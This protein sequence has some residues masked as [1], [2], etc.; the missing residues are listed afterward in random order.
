MLSRC[1]SA[2][3]L[4]LGLLL[5]SS[6]AFGQHVSPIE[7]SLDDLASV[8]ISSVSKYVQPTRE[9][10]AAV[11]VISRAEISRY[12]WR[13]L[14]EALNSLP[15]LYNTN[16]RA[17]DYLGGRGFAV[18]G[19]YN[20][21]YL[22]LIDGSRVNDYVYGQASIGR[23]FSLD[24]AL[25]ERI[26]FVP[27][28]GSAIY[29]GNAIFGVINVITRRGND[30]SPLAVSSLAS[31][32]G[33]REGRIAG[34]QRYESG[35]VVTLSYSAANRAGSDTRYDDPGNQ[36]LIAG[37][38]PSPDGIARDL[39]HERVR[40]LLGRYEYGGLTISG[41]YAERNVQPSSALYGTLF[42]DPALQLKDGIAGLTGR[43]QRRISDDSR[44]ELR[45]DYS[46]VTYKGTYPYE[47]G[48]GVRY[49]NE[50][51]TVGTSWQGD[52]RY[53]YS[54]L[55]A[56][57]WLFGV[58]GQTLNARQ[59]NDNLNGLANPAINIVS[60]A[61][62]L[63]FYVQDEW[64]FAPDWRLSLGV[65]HDRPSEAEAMTSPRVGLVW[66]PNPA[67]SLK[68]LYGQAYRLPVPYERDYANGMDYLSNTS[69]KPE[70][71]STLEAVW[72][73]RFGYAHSLRLAVFDYI[74]KR[75]ISLQQL[76]GNLFQYQNG[77]QVKA[78]GVETSWHTKWP[79]GARIDASLAYTRTADVHGDALNNAPRWLGK[80]RG[81]LPVW[82]NN[83]WLALESCASTRTDYVWN[84]QQ[85][86]Q[87]AGGLVNLTLT[88]ERV[89]AGLDIQLRIRNLFDRR[90][91]YPASD[92]VASPSVPG[93]GR[94]G[95]LG[96]S[97]AF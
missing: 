87:P 56:H 60:N 69:L 94:V 58:E 41:R 49:L 91:A 66:L 80:L 1:V 4:G 31:S 34:S 47:S 36:L 46:R 28:P 12:G 33:W 45:L 83:W 74:L 95:E 54:G 27:G 37:G 88:G 70:E 55:E 81:M 7:L 22:L 13:T 15:G 9:A 32:D 48:A 61:E 14:S 26:E 89:W 29:G 77:E 90:F 75:L 3:Q 25:I 97:Y 16:D 59:R 18:P 17:Y 39:D 92:E 51:R 65:R 43:Y 62:R 86:R 6:L 38:Q 68:L 84:G 19:D 23:D 79:S 71:I 67:T 96:F 21:R 10:P 53:F 20:T 78:H 63:G 76:P 2:D 40:R 30:I 35:A 42:N 57:Q 44:F 5:F 11:E 82:R 93:F 8:Q 72:E 24:M 85:L 64:R 73:Q 50:D 52:F